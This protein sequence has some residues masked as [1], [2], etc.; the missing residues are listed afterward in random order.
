MTNRRSSQTQQLEERKKE[1]LDTLSGCGGFGATVV[2]ME[3]DRVD[4]QIAEIKKREDENDR[5]T[6]DRIFKKSD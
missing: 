1:L 5:R 6:L 3:L 2:E 4:M